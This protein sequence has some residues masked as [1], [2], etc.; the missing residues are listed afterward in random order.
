MRSMEITAKRIV[1]LVG[2]CTGD[3]NDCEVFR[4]AFALQ[5]TARDNEKTQAIRAELVLAKVACDQCK[6]NYLA[7]VVL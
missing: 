7:D 1:E 4:T 5:D 2:P 3:V 6:T